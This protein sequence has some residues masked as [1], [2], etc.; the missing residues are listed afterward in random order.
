MLA[1]RNPAL[2]S[3][4]AKPQGYRASRHDIGEAMKRIGGFLAKRET[5]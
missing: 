5:A 2:T 1:L 4:R 3:Q